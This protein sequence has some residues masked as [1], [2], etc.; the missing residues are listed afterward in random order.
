M[1]LILFT[2]GGLFLLLFVAVAGWK[3]ACWGVRTL[4]GIPRHPPFIEPPAPDLP[5]YLDDRIAPPD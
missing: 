2:V 5:H 4:L 3:L 1:A